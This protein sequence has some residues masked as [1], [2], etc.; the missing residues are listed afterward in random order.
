L[1]VRTTKTVKNVGCSTIKTLIENNKLIIN[2]FDIISEFTTFISQKSSYAAEA[3]SY[4]D[5]VM[6]LVLFGWLASQKN[7]IELVTDQLAMDSNSSNED[8]KPIFGYNDHQENDEHYEKIGDD[9]WL[10]SGKDF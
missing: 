9:F 1:G 5:L 4:D 3:G 2:D 7:F 10:V 6:C 8:T